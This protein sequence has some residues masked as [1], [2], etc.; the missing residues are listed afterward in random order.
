MSVVCLDSSSVLVPPV[1]GL[2]FDQ[3]SKRCS[4]QHAMFAS[5]ETVS[6]RSPPGAG[7][8]KHNKPSR[9][10]KACKSVLRSTKKTRETTH[11]DH[12]KSLEEIALRT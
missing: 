1:G 8:C 7:F 4:R 3:E 10:M 6:D 2:E 9:V 11:A 12:K 5:P